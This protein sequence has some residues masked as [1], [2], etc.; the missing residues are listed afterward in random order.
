M[1]TQINLRAFKLEDAD[2]INLLRSNE[3]VENMI[4]GNKRFISLERDYKWVEDIIFKDYQD[5]I[6]V[7]LFEKSDPEQKIIGYAS[8]IN[9]DHV[10]KSCEWGGIKLDESHNGKGFGTMTSLMLLKYVFEELN[11]E[12]Y[13]GRCLENHSV[14]LKMMEKTGFKIEGLL[15]HTLFKNGSYQ[16]EILLS[17]LK[18]EYKEMKNTFDL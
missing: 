12:R 14:S 8:I 18:S 11:M 7:S 5:R 16:N 1:E 10:N 15:R 2:F 17:I 6:F 4:G 3:G 9:I 13:V